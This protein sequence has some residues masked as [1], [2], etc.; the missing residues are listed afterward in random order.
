MHASIWLKGG[1]N[2]SQ[3]GTVVLTWAS[4]ITA[5]AAW[6]SSLNIEVREDDVASRSETT[7]TGG[8]ATGRTGALITAGSF[9]V[10]TKYEIV[11]VGTTDFTLI[12]AAS[13]TVGLVFTATG[14]GSGTGDAREALSSSTAFVFCLFGSEGPSGD[15]AGTAQIRDNG[16]LA[17]AN[18]GQRVGTA[19]APPVSNITAHEVWLELT[20]DHFTRGLVSGATSRLWANCLVALEERT[21]LRRT[22]ITPTDVIETEQITADAGGDPD[23]LYWGF[24]EDTGLWEA[25][26]T[27]TP[28][29]LRATS[30]GDGI[31][32][33]V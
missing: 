11:T 7:A 6:A 33:T 17:T 12:G 4:A 3:T 8:P 30:P 9:V 16:L 1:Y 26:E 31:W 14:V 23:N 22:G 13:N 5:K 32:T 27:T 15:T 20:T 21:D 29:T 18:L 10:G 28:G 19:G 25:Y 2:K 24:N